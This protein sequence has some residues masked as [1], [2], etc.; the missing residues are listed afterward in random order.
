MRASP[1]GASVT[2]EQLERDPHPVLAA[3]RERE[4]V[5][6]VPALDGWLVT[7]YEL[8]REVLHDP[9]RFTVDDERFTTARVLGPSMLSLDGAEH[10]RHREPFV[11]PL[12]PGAVR[13]RFAVETDAQCEALIDAL[14]PRGECELLSEF[15]GPLAAG[16]LSR[17]LGLD[18]CEAPAVRAWYQAIVAAVTELTAGKPL[19]RAGA[20]AYAALSRRLSERLNGDEPASLLA[21]AAEDGGLTQTELIAN[22]GVLLFGGIETTEGMIANAALAMLSRPEVLGRVRARPELVDNALEESLRLEPAASVVDRYATVDTTL[23]GVAI[24][25]RELVRVSLA[26]ASRDPRVFSDPDRFDLDRRRARPHLAFAQGPHVCVGVHLAR[27]EAR[28]ALRALVSRLPGLRLDPN[29]PAGVRGLVFRKPPELHVQWE[30][31]AA[32]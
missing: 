10:G 31:I 27:L 9:V 16:V 7:S 13:A 26:A 18:S 32:R 30:V 2:I 17:A 20:E 21:A 4:P 5:S 3:L 14:A 1:I 6:W 24:G 22:A 28:V 15:A 23:G 12:R 11:A 29:R 25:A 19:P 8:A